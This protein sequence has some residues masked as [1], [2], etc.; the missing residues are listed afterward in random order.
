MSNTPYTDSLI[1][2]INTQVIGSTALNYNIEVAIEDA[3]NK[4]VSQAARRAVISALE[5][6]GIEINEELGID[7]FDPRVAMRKVFDRV[8][9]IASEEVKQ[10]VNHSRIALTAMDENINTPKHCNNKQLRVLLG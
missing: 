6:D 1:K 2:A 4:T 9:K 8:V 7:D 5:E 3:I 10:H